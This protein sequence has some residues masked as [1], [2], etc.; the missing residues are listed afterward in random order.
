MGIHGPF[1]CG[2]EG[3]FRRL[4]SLE[5]GPMTTET[6]VYRIVTEEEWTAL[7]T[8]GVLPLSAL[9]QR[10][11]FV[12]LS[13]RD[14]VLETANL[15]YSQYETLRVLQMKATSLGTSLRFEPVRSRK[16]ALFP[17]YYGGALSSAV[18]EQSLWLHRSSEGFRWA[19]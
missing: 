4:S 15:Y 1:F 11:G 2:D 8:G 16:G 10:D 6:D 19:P 3:G 12:H 18:I 13:T 5:E 7:E 17:H 14:T 9:D